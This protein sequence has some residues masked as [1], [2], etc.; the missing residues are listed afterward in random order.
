MQP[1]FQFSSFRSRIIAW[2]VLLL[3]VVL[4]TVFVFVNR[5]T[6]TNTRTVI[7]DNLAIGREVL[8]TLLAEREAT[9][10]VTF[11][12][13][14]LDFG[15]REAYRSADYET[16]L[17]A[18][19]NLLSRTENADILMVVDYDYRMVADTQRLY[20]PGTDFP[21]PYLLE[22]AEDDP[23][24]QAAS[25]ILMD[26]VAY[27]IVAVPILTP[28]VDGWIIVGQRLDREYVSSL[29]NIISSD[30]SIL[31]L[32]ER[33]SGLSLATTLPDHQ[34]AELNA[35]YNHYSAGDQPTGMVDLADE[36]FVTLSSTLVSRPELNLVALIQQSLP[37]ALAPYR[38]LE[39]RL[40]VLFALGLCLSAV[41]AMFLGRSV[42]RPVLSLVNRVGRIERG[43]YRSSGETWRTDEIGRLENSVNRMASGLAEKEKVRDLLGKVVS[44]EIA[45]ELMRG[46]VKLGGETRQATILFSD[47]RDFTTLCE[48][49]PPEQIL[50]MLN[51][52]LTE[53]T[54]AIE[55]NKGV[56]DKYIGD[57]VMALFGAPI[58]SADDVSNALAAALAMKAR[59][60]SMNAVNRDNGM[61]L[62]NTGIGLHTGEVVAGNLGSINRMNYTVIGDAVNLASRLE[63]LT[64]QYGA[65]ILVSEDTRAQGPDFAYREIDMVRVKGKSRP[66]RIYELLG[67][68][69]TLSDAMTNDVAAFE[70]ALQYYRSADWETAEK[71]LLT[72]QERNPDTVLYALFLTRLAHFRLQPP[73]PDWD[74]VFTFISK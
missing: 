57:A 74:G 42:S 59:V 3:L 62:L 58:S 24:Y 1:R 30:V 73:P 56:V 15:F 44:R 39:Q 43:D 69:G 27:H 31:Q 52:Y 41:L 72:L 17:S 54:G 53:V 35:E 18:G 19:Q 28:L 23:E 32:S 26:G 61:P 36:N 12:A 64:K 68:D 22:D 37:Q 60:D 29:K 4:G 51:H 13:L 50:E 21:W 63:A 10:K 71:I 20:L 70:T 46:E 6:Y 55:A 2:L 7:D 65:G 8:Q 9:F 48:G 66:V 67:H 45:D 33:G 40:I 5:S 47:I 11:N 25:Y 14:A 38:V 49:R 16:M 34:A